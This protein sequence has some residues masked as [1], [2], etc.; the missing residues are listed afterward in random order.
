MI[1]Q[2]Q[3]PHTNMIFVRN[4]QNREIFV[5]RKQIGGCQ[6]AGM[7]RGVGSSPSKGGASFWGDGN[8]FELEKSGGCATLQMH[9]M[10]LNGSLLCG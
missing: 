7:Q 1:S 8:T 5:D 3:I 4:V 9:Q 10:P 6:A 2:T